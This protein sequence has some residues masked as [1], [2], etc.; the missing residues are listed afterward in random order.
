MPS[1]Q[2]ER[3]TTTKAETQVFAGRIMATAMCAIGPL[4]AT[5]QLIQSSVAVLLRTWR[6][7]DAW[8][9]RL[10]RLL[11]GCLAGME[12]LGR[13]R[14][15]TDLGAIRGRA[16]KRGYALCVTTVHALTCFFLFWLLLLG[17]GLGPNVIP[18]YSTLGGGGAANVG[19]SCGCF[20]LLPM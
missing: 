18:H 20:F 1:R 4:R 15:Q 17:E 3:F 8:R 13:V 11:H 2:Q 19:S 9:P 5:C 6:R 14:Y 16:C 10:G 12:P 7:R